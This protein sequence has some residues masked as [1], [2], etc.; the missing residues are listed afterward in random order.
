M[1]AQ[2]LNISIR[3]LVFIV[4]CKI[5]VLI[6]IFL[7]IVFGVTIYSFRAKPVYEVGATILLKPFLDSRQ[8]LNMANRFDVE[9]VTQQDIMTEIKIIS[10]RELMMQVVEKLN[11][12]Q[13][14]ELSKFKR[15]LI[16]LGISFQASP[17]DSAVSNLRK[18]LEISPIT[19]SN[20][21]I[22]LMKGS[23]PD[24]IT[25]IVNTLLD[26][27]I[28]RHIDVYKST[29]DLD[30]YLHQADLSSQKLVRY[31]NELKKFQ[32]QWSIIDISAQNDYSL[33]LIQVLRETLSTI[34]G[35]IAEKQNKL[36]QLNE[37]MRQYDK[38][39]AM[40][41][42]FR[43]NEVFI[44]LTRTLI[45]LLIEKQRIASLYPESSVEFI[46]IVKQV[47]RFKKEISIA[48]KQLLEGM[49]YDLK[50]LSKQAKS[51]E[52]EIKRIEAENKLLV[53]KDIER[54]Q[55]LRKV[56]Q[57]Q[58][59]YMLYLDKAEEARISRARE[60]NR[61]SNVSINSRAYKPS[62]PEYPQKKKMIFIAIIVG[63]IAS[64]GG[65]FVTYFLDHTIK[66]PED[67]SGYCRIPVLATLENVKPA[68]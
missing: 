3:D 59:I 36:S 64:L 1:D 68:Q 47:E 57:E 13:P 7:I 29:G 50:A 33:K 22:V 58:K 51:I 43:D 10:S 4:F 37:N 12:A 54:Q 15:L 44:R 61:V 11:L 55:L 34:R 27:Y 20:M 46:N 67:L 49:V 56:T 25:K 26:L 66:K 6:G 63:S 5:H 19:M 31:E 45:P 17:L 39:T 18:R 35:K 48:Q 53:E 40:T 65:V 2:R 52:D 38:I 8:Y 28:D 14:E 9:T 42:E 41:E 21:I 32:Q 60:I 24:R 62:V 23:N 30:F 16:R